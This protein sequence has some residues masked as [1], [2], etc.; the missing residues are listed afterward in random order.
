M[1]MDI[2]WGLFIPFL[3]TSLGGGLCVFYAGKNASRRA[4]GAHWFCFR[5]HGGGFYL[6][7]SHS[8]H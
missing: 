8:G 2:F 7:S 1:N 4:A 3:G 5:R 6:E